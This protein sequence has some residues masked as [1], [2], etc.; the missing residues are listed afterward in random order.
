VRLPAL[1]SDNMVL[2]QGREVPLWGTA[3]AGEKVTVTL[4]EQQVAATAD[5]EGRWQ[6][7]LAPL[8]AGGPFDVTIAGNNTITLHNVL[9]GEVWIGS[10]QSNMQM[11]VQASANAEQEI[12]AANYP[13]IRL[14]STKLVVAGEPQR[15]TEGRWVECSPAAV[16]GFSAV[17]YFFGRDLHKALGVPMGL[18][19]SAWGGT[20]AEAWT[21]RSGL[22]AEPDFKPL[23]ERWDY[24]CLQ[25]LEQHASSEVVNL[26]YRA[27]VEISE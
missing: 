23:L 11:S 20:P 17:E 22:E 5:R 9:V 7:R 10:G 19:Q 12:A 3:G 27:H 2:Q 24:A 15:E 25:A 14:F 16:P 8:K 6:V 13:M 1:L 4:G 21:S 18:I 26:L